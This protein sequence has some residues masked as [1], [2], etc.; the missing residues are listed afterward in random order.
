MYLTLALRE[1]NDGKSGSS[2]VSYWAFKS[3]CLGCMVSRAGLMPGTT[4]YTL[5]C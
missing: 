1:K 3:K 2:E 5:V 4:F